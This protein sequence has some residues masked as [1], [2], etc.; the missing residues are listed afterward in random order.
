MALFN[1][2]LFPIDLSESS[3]KMVPFVKEV[4]NRFGAELHIVYSINIAPYYANSSMSTLNID[5]S[6]HDIR[7][8]AEKKI[9]GFIESQF[10]GCSVQ[11]K[12]LAG[13]PGQEI[14]KCVEEEKMDLII[15]G[16]SSK[17]LA[18]AAFGSVAGYVTKHSHIPVLIINSGIQVGMASHFWG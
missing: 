1:K 5:E 16:R 17:G 3:K 14:L 10:N 12:I 8:E 11:S 2:I 6:E 13:P 15:L 4:I 7:T 18:E 9:R